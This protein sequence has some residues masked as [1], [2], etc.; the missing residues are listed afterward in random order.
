MTLPGQASTA[1]F[2]PVISRL[3]EWPTQTEGSDRRS[4]AC[5]ELRLL[6]FDLV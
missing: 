3:D 1:S 4:P 6:W 2:H 5:N